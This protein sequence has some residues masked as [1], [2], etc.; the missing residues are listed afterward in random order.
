MERQLDR[1]E[2]VGTDRC[3][4]LIYREEGEVGTDRCIQH[5]TID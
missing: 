1:K 2:E 3:I 4:Q 5:K